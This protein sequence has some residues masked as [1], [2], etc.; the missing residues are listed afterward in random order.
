MVAAAGNCVNNDPVVCNTAH[1]PAALID[2][3][4]VSGV[5]DNGLFASTSPCVDPLGN[6]G[7]S[8]YGDWVDLA[9]PFWSRSAVNNG[10]YEDEDERWCGT[11][12]ATP[13]VTGTVALM[14]AKNPTIPNW[15]IW[16]I[17]LGHAQDTGDP[18]WDIF[19]GDGIVRADNAV[20]AVPALLQATIAGPTRFSPTIPAIG[21]LRLVAE[22][23]GIPSNGLACSRERVIRSPVPCPRPAPSTWT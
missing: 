15:Q 23:A 13:F 14:R 20:A 16:N 18:G 9:A 17:L 21:L 22:R 11:S 3:I 5:R 1:Y 4:G 7:T 12:M 10:G 8:R 19:Y 2:V 6:V